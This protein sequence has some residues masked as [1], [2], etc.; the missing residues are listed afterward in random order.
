MSRAFDRPVRR[1]PTIAA[2]LLL[3]WAVAAFGQP[4]A[5]PPTTE[6]LNAQQLALA[7]NLRRE[8]WRATGTGVQYRRLSGPDPTDSRR[9]R[10]EDRVTVH[11][12]GSFTNGEVFDSSF[13][14]GEPVSFQLSRLVRGW[15]DVVPLMAIGETWEIL[16]PPHRGYGY[17]G[18]GPIPGGAVLRFRIELRAIGE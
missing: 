10:L 18:R 14:R 5:P 8:G 13:A 16:V 4:Q 2:T 15:Q 6:Y 3:T 17:A 7:E 1:C 11:Y 9:A 12:E